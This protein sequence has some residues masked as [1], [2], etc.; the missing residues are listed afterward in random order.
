MENAYLISPKLVS[1][2]KCIVLAWPESSAVFVQPLFAHLL[3]NQYSIN[4][5]VTY[6]YITLNTEFVAL[7]DGVICASPKRSSCVFSRTS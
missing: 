3:L 2:P 1:C 5:L 4:L 6:F 7:S